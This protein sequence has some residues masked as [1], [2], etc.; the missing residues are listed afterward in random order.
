MTNLYTYLRL[1]DSSGWELFCYFIT[2][3]AAQGLCMVQAIIVSLEIHNYYGGLI[4][5]ADIF[6]MNL[7]LLAVFCHQILKIQARVKGVT[8]SWI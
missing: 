7:G 2:L 3:F 4:P 6:D 8:E 1:L 5:T